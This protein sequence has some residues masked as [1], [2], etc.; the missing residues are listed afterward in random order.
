MYALVLGGLILPLVPALRELSLRQDAKPLQVVR[1]YDTNIRHF[2]YS[3]RNQLQSLYSKYRIDPLRPPQSFEGF[4]KDKESFQF[5][6]A[7]QQFDPKID[8]ERLRTV[9]RMIV[10]GGSLNLPG[11]FVFEQ[12]LFAAETITVGSTSTLRAIFSDKDIVLA[13]NCT[14]ARWIHA[15]N[16][17]DAGAGCQLYGR[18]SANGKIILNENTQFERLS[19]PLIRTGNVSHPIPSL[20]QQRHHFELPNSAMELDERTSLV[21]GAITTP[22]YAVITRN[23]VATNAIVIGAQNLIDGSVKSHVSIHVGPS[24]VIRGA[25][26]CEHDIHIAEGC[27]I[28]GPVIAEGVIFIGPHCVVGTRAMETS[29]S[30]PQVELAIGSR[31]SGT[32]WATQSGRVLSQVGN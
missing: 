23:I 17:I 5:V 2:A 29:I 10:G 4:W 21:T 13:K 14:V 18:C 26:V 22:D 25:L 24:T 3:F 12:E 32:I 1:Q 20:N 28:A 16:K 6:G 15:D 30:A 27:V 11:D 7:R 31:F 19:A 8:E 9:Q